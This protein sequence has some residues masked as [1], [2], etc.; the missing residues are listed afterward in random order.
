[1]FKTR[2]FSILIF[3]ILFPVISQANATL[4]VP[5]APV[6][7]STTSPV[8]PIYS[9]AVQ[10]DGKIVVGGNFATVNSQLRKNIARLNA[11]GSLDTSFETGTGT[12]ST[13]EAVAVQAD[14]KILIA[15]S[16]TQYNGAAVSR[17]ARL[18][19][20]GSLDASFAPQ[21]NS[22][23][24]VITLQ[25]DGK[26]LIGGNLTNVNGT[27]VGRIARLNSDGSLDTTFNTGTG[28]TS[29]VNDIVVQT[30]GKIL[31]GGQFF[32]FNSGNGYF[33]RLNANGSIDTTFNLGS[34]ADDFVY[35]IALQT[36]GKIIIGG[37]FDSYNGT[38]RFN[39]A[40][41]NADGTLDT[42]LTSPFAQSTIISEADL[43]ADGKIIVLGNFALLGGQ[44]R[45]GIARLNSNGMVDT[46]FAGSGFDNGSASEVTVLADGKILASGF[47]NGYSGNAAI[48]IIRLNAGG[49]FDS[50]F[51]ARTG[52]MAAVNSIAVQPDGKILIGGSFGLV[53]GFS[54]NRIAR[55]NADGTTDTSFDPGTGIPEGYVNEIA[56]QADG[57]IVIVGSFTSFNGTPRISIARLNA[58]GT[59]DT[60][61]NTGTMNSGTGEADDVA[62]TAGGKILVS[63]NFS[64]FNGVS[65]VG[66]A[67]FNTDGSLDTTFVS[68]LTSGRIS[69]IAV[70]SD[71]KIVI[72]GL[73]NNY[74][75]SSRDIARINADGTLDTSF[76]AGTGTNN[77]F[78]IAIQP[79]GKIV[80]GGFLFS[81]NGTPRNGV[82]RINS[83]GSLDTTF[84]PGTGASDLVR[85]VGIDTKGRIWIGGNFTQYNGAP[86]GRVAQLN[87]DGSLGKTFGTGSDGTVSAFGFYGNKTL[88]GGFITLFNGVLRGSLVRVSEGLTAFDYDGDSKADISI[89]R[90]SNGEWWIRR[91]SSSVFAAQF[92][93]TGDK[94]TPAD[95]TGDG[96]TDLAFFRPSLG[97]WFVLRSEDSSFYSFPFGAS[98]DIPAV[99]D[100]DGDGKADAGVFRPS[101]ATWFIQ[102]STGGVMIENFGI[103]NDVPVVGDYDGDGK[104]DIAIF[105]P[106]NGQWWLKRST[107]GIIAAEFG[108]SNDKPVQADFTGDGKTDMAFWR[109]STGEWFVL[110]SEDSSFYA[111]PFGSTNDIPVPADYDGDGKADAAV[112]RPS[113]S[114]WYLLQSQSGITAVAFGANGDIPTPTA[115]HQ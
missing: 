113:N 102:K 11:D 61:F 84:D 77:V 17:I 108:S 73:F 105:R 45:R 36:D 37:I 30:D 44:T 78:D 54:R 67:R 95:F 89:F 57:K 5:F 111:F 28:A 72:G 107:A 18:N 110:R 83:N 7:E 74:N 47:I 79:D 94:I 22:T 56:L 81:Y 68:Q 99:G 59:L 76:N 35:T 49:S 3:T 12:N 2:I 96:K 50:A 34:G 19:S 69:A 40:R 10:T 39:F 97:E 64:S 43:Q 4:D 9:H 23:I 87:S 31:V 85:E 15:G 63:G 55:L 26:I 58:D 6:I 16:F 112:F 52:S 80:I 100:F 8:R 65:R 46:T 29:T 60:G 98:G 1:M 86:V 71:G 66:I 106:S 101:T 93:G 20:D 38:A 103:A 75:G 33:L 32:S 53:N 25:T 27:S 13:V 104:A 109:E 82:A 42:T 92:G 91:S 41:V 115:Y 51:Q 14:G 48:A 70:Q 90:P 62:I 21:V 88:I 24:Y 114:V